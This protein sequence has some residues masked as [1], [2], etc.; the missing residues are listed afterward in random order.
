MKIKTLLACALCLSFTEMSA[1]TL[2][3]NS[4]T[5]ASSTA[6]T[7]TTQTDTSVPSE[8][9]QK[10]KCNSSWDFSYLF[11]EDGW[12]LGIDAVFN[13]FN[14]GFKYAKG[15]ENDYLKDNKSWALSM[16]YNGR[17]WLG[18]S[19][20]IEARAGL[21]YVSAS[22]EIVTGTKENTKTVGYGSNKKTYTTTETI[23]EEVSDS[24]FGLYL[25]PRVGL[26]LGESV[27][28]TAGYEWDISEF[29]FDKEHTNDYFTLGIS[30]IF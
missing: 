1:Q 21:Q 19:I 3:G 18:P 4:S 27:A 2:T 17:Y 8:N 5:D 12:G 7:K 29:K 10:D 9:D 13:H 26:A 20:Y 6:I 15:E 24:N 23:W 25:N 22:C 28:V 30:Y 11:V 14:I 16:G